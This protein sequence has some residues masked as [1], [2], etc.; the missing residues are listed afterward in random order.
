MRTSRQVTRVVLPGPVA[1]VMSGGNAESD[2]VWTLKGNG[3]VVSGTDVH[4][5]ALVRQAHHLTSIGRGGGIVAILLPQNEK[6]AKR[7][8][9]DRIK[10]ALVQVRMRGQ[11][12][13]QM[14]RDLELV[15][16]FLV[17]A[18]TFAPSHHLSSWKAKDFLKWLIKALLVDG[19]DV[20]RIASQTFPL[21]LEH[22][23]KLRWWQDRVAQ[24]R[25][26]SR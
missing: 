4:K 20:R 3:K 22:S 25:K 9:R 10:Y 6:E 21:I 2:W 11:G 13:R 26:M 7:L 14:T 5:R 8:Q 24:L 1:K 12:E 15:K 23:R 18:L 19:S 16:S 17:H